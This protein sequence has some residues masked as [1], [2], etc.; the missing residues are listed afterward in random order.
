MEQ[1]IKPAIW[2]IAT[3]DNLMETLPIAS[4]S[5]KGEDPSTAEGKENSIFE[6]VEQPSTIW[7]DATKEDE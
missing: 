3:P 6:D 5:G 1:Y 2:V 7:E 4:P